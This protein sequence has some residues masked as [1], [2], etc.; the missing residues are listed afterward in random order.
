MT[1]FDI[2]SNVILAEGGKALAAGLKGNQVITELNI[3][4]NK[5][6]QTISGSSYVSET[7]GVV[8]IANAIPDMR[9]LTK[10]DI[11]RNG[12]GAEQE[13]GLQRICVAGGIELAK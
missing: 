2:S 12:L 3:A 6:G 4:G 5:L 9:A 1:K 13:G 10:L 11:S 8:A 7:S